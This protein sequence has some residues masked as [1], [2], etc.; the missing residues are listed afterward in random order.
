VKIIVLKKADKIGEDK[1][2]HFENN[3]NEIGDKNYFIFVLFDYCF[4]SPF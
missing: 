2:P 1:K 4:F 3:L